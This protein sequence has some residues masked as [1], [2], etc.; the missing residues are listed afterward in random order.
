M[1]H[2]YQVFLLGMLATGSLSAAA[3]VN[4]AETTNISSMPGDCSTL[5][6]VS[7][8]APTA[9]SATAFFTLGNLQ[10]GDVGAA[11]WIDPSGSQVDSTAFDP[12]SKPGA[13][14][15]MS[16]TPIAGTATAAKPG[17]WKVQILVNGS[18][19]TTVPFTIT[20]S[21]TE[22]SPSLAINQV[23]TSKCPGVTLT[24]TVTDST[25]ATVP[26]LG[27]S[28]FTLTEDG[29]SRTITNVT[30]IGGS[31]SSNGLSVALV[32]D[33]SGSIK[34][35]GFIPQL[36]SAA[37]AFVDQL[38]QGVPI[39][40]YLVRTQPYLLQPFTTDKATLHNQIATIGDYSGDSAILDT[41]A[42]AAKSFSTN[43]RA[44]VLLSDG[45]DN[46]SV[47]YQCGGLS[48]TAG[49]QGVVQVANQNQVTNYT[50]GFGDTGLGSF[51][52][53]QDVLKGLANG[54]QG[55]YTQASTT[56]PP[57]TSTLQGILLQLAGL[58]AGG[59]GTPVLYLVTYTSVEN[60]SSNHNITLAATSGGNSSTAVPS[61]V[62]ACTPNPGPGPVVIG[63][64]VMTNIY[65]RTCQTPQA[66]SSFAPTAAVASVYFTLINLKSTDTV[67]LVWTAPDQS[68]FLTDPMP[69]ASNP[70]CGWDSLP[71]AGYPPAAKPGNWTVRIVVDRNVLA[72]VPFTIL[73]PGMP[74]LNLNVNQIDTSKCPSVSL[75]VSVKDGAGATVFGLGATNISLRED[76]ALR[77]IT[78][79]TPIGSGTSLQ[80][81]V[82]Y[83]SIDNSTATHGIMLI[84]SSGGVTSAPAS[85][86]VNACSRPSPTSVTIGLTE[87]TNSVL[88][89]AC[90]TP[91]A[92]NTFAPTAPTAYVY[93][94]LNNLKPADTVHILWFDPTGSLYR[95]DSP[96]A[97]TYSANWCLYNGMQIAGN[98]PASEP[99]NW[100]VQIVVNGTVLATVPFTLTGTSGGGGALNLDINPADTGNCPSVTVAVTVKDGNGAP[101]P[102]LSSNNFALTEDGQPRSPSVISTGNGASLQYLITYTSGGG[103]TT[104][105]ISLTLTTGGLTS[106]AVTQSVAACATVSLTRSGVLSHIPA[107]GGWDTTITLI[108]TSSVGVAITVLLRADDGGA[109]T[110]P[111]RIT[112][113]G[114]SR[115]TVAN[116][117]NAT[118][119]SNGT[120]LIATGER[121]N[122]V[123]G[124][125]D[126]LSSAP[127]NGF[128]IMRYAPTNDKPSEATVPL[129]AQFPS[130]L[131]LAYDNTAG[132][133]MGAALVNLASRSATIN[134]TIWDENGSRLGVQ[135]ITIP[136]GGHT[137]FVLPDNLSLTTGRRGTIQFENTSGGVA[138]LGLRFSPAGPFT[139]VPVILQ[140]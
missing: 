47:Q 137:A 110:L 120:I 55:T 112:Q 5:P 109:L 35:G 125:V 103:T 136:G 11:H 105:T 31:G 32:L 74:A 44:L 26:G 29:Q 58:V 48:C 59:V 8:F 2:V 4:V 115:T 52:F 129:Q 14:C 36:Q 94:V 66:V 24:V 34:A 126:V 50:I 79:A 118:I 6:Q 60:G 131:T 91:P 13:W 73:A 86:T 25:G 107:G 96:M 87:M 127:V 56:S 121:A 42:Q 88:S 39:E 15:F 134:A 97:I 95:S 18:Q 133:V 77:S 128:A 140:Q 135:Q 93:Y 69:P 53:A 33:T 102:G 62:K 1:K 65:P 9:A 82:T 124:W 10:Q 63:L 12:I 43:R 71:I 27:V 45:A 111:L 17:S 85:S 28:N 22:G 30:Q 7:S 51:T 76:G 40:I 114:A 106:S 67:N 68:I 132:Y 130:S 19:V 75:T 98:L 23:D 46:A 100:K 89:Q 116:T 117:L 70:P 64:A 104:H 20:G 38:P 49:M 113:Q 101:V 37:N 72:S 61:S 108:N 92:I 138:G 83:T 123:V 54:T 57:T 41:V 78:S 139:D 81:L 3:T 122:T 90:Q 80:Y 21:T 99:G 84:V 16:T 119:N